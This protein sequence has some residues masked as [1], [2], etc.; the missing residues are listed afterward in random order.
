MQ[1]LRERASHSRSSRQAGILEP[2][3]QP[4]KALWIPVVLGVGEIGAGHLR[5]LG[6]QRGD[7]ATG[8]IEPASGSLDDC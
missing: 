7:M 4:P 8:G 2:G 1:S 5:M 3:E 6:E